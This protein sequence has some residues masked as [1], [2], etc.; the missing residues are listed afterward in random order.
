[1][2]KFLWSSGQIRLF[3]KLKFCIKIQAKFKTF[4][5]KWLK[6]KTFSQYANSCH[7]IFGI[8]WQN[9]P[10][11]NR[12]SKDETMCTLT[13]ITDHHVPMGSNQ[14][15]L[16]PAWHLFSR[17]GLFHLC[18]NHSPP[19]TSNPSLMHET[20]QQLVEIIHSGSVATTS[21]CPLSKICG[22]KSLHEFFTPTAVAAPFTPTPPA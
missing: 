2:T 10:R 13:V 6:Y 20:K 11:E 19:T 12:K 9:Y 16:S 15:M 8:I 18:S 7:K 1:M 21:F 14:G 22:R 3:T 17:A 4:L 5:E